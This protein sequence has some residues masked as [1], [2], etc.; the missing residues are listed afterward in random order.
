MN[1]PERPSLPE[2]AAVIA[3]LQ[4]YRRTLG[5]PEAD[6]TEIRVHL[7]ELRASIERVDHVT[8]SQ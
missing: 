2:T 6:A 8:S 1:S 3:A 5:L 4:A 7:A